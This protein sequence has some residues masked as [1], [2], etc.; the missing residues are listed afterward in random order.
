M[1]NFFISISFFFKVAVGKH[2]RDL[3]IMVEEQRKL[4]VGV[5]VGAFLEKY[6]NEKVSLR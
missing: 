4:G 1:I 2:G 6:S 3:R 5:V